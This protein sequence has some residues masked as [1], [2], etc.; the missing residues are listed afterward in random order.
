MCSVSGSYSK[1]CSLQ[2]GIPQGTILGPVFFLLY[3]N[4]LPNCLTNAYPRIYD[5]DKHLTYA[6]KDVSIIQSCLNEDLLNVS[7]W[8]IANK[9]TRNM[10][11]TEFI[12]IGSRQKLN[13]GPNC[14]SRSEH[15]WYSPKPVINVKTSRCTHWCK[16][17]TWCSHIDMLAKKIASG[18]AA[19]IRV[20]Q[21][22]PQQHCILSTKPWFSHISTIAMLFGESVA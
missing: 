20:R 13:T 22:V 16:P 18:I 1:T 17:V 7:K 11:N 5:H 21:F 12:L 6:D 3:I 19:I 9:L 8:L 2:G 10:T 4:V 14:L 15:Q